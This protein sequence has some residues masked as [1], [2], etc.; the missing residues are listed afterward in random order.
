MDNINAGQYE[1]LLCLLKDD[2]N[3]YVAIKWMNPLFTYFCGLVQRY[4]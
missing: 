2:K 4:L 3:D 1:M